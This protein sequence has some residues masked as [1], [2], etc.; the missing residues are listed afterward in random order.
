MERPELKKFRLDP[1]KIVKAERGKYV[2]AALTIVRAFMRRKD[3]WKPLPPIKNYD[4][5]CAMVRDPLVWLGCADPC[6]T[7]EQI[8][9][10]DRALETRKASAALV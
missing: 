1:L 4:Q 7:M 8:R 5:W 9:K 2:V 6:E 10:T 3:S